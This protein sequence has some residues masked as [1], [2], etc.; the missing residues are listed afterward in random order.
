MRGNYSTTEG[1]LSEI[2]AFWEGRGSLEEEVL[3]SLLGSSKIHL[4]AE[5]KISSSTVVCLMCLSCS[6]GAVS[7]VCLEEM[8]E[9]GIGMGLPV[10]C[11]GR[12]KDCLPLMG[13]R[14]APSHRFE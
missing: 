12:R 14:E 11:E 9:L 13:E 10:L 2:T 3:S 4:Q 7:T 6:S 1:A 8:N 5:A